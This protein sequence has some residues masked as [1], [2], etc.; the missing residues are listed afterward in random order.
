MK[1]M[2]GLSYY[3]DV[4][5]YFGCLGCLGLLPDSNDRL[6]LCSMLL[7]LACVVAPLCASRWK[8]WRRWLFM[9][10]V[11]AVMLIAGAPGPRIACIAPC[12]Y[13]GL[14]VKNNSTVADYYYAATKFRSELLGLI[15]LVFLIFA[16]SSPVWTRGLPWM[17]LYFTLT[18]YLMRMLRHDDEAANSAR[19]RA[20]NLATLCAVCALGWLF[21]RPVAI[22]VLSSAARFLLDHVLAPIASVL[23][24]IIEYLLIALNRLLMPFFPNTVPMEEMSQFEAA[25]SM[26]ELFAPQ[27]MEQ[28]AVNPIA[29]IILIGIGIALLAVVGWFILRALSHQMA[30]GADRGQNDVRESLKEEEIAHPRRPSKN[31]G[32]SAEGVRYWYWKSLDYMKR[33]NGTVTPY[34]NTHQIETTNSER[35]DGDAL[36]ILLEIYLPVRYNAQN[37]D[38]EAEK[39]MKEAYERMKRAGVA[40]SEAN[41]GKD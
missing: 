37:V 5:L 19:F 18:I 23:L 33:R 20:V 4:L 38:R 25:S 29:R 9:V 34:M 10:S 16:N 39:R 36:Q 40:Q 22:A 24:F 3:C 8:D 28:S 12:V 31:R 27:V 13:L 21:S 26:E 15:F 30:R 17:L 35:F 11:P 6:M 14:Y 32:N 1:L 41:G 2:Y 7:F